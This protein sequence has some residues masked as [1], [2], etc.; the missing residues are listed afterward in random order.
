[1]LGCEVMNASDFAPLLA[2]KVAGLV[3][4]TMEQ[5]KLSLLSAMSKVYHSKLYELLEREETKLWHH[6]PYLLHDALVSE[7]L[8][9]FPELPDE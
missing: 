6:S 3:E 2:V 9:G 5:D 1:M 4:C 7:E 8:K